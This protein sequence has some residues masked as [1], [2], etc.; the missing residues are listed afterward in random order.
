MMYNTLYYQYT[1]YMHMYRYNEQPVQSSHDIIQDTPRT[2]KRKTAA[3]QP[4]K[5]CLA[6]QC[7]K[8]EKKERRDGQKEL[9]RHR[10][11]WTVSSWFPEGSRDEEM[12]KKLVKLSLGSEY[13]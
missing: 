3:I 6:R 4:H 1:I 10:L 11:E 13:K 5:G 12:W 2:A 9:R 7:K 8:G